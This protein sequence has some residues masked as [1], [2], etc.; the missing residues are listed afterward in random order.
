MTKCKALTGSAVK[1]LKCTTIFSG[2]WAP[3]EPAGRV[4]SVS[5]DSIRG[6]GKGG[7][8]QEWSAAGTEIGEEIERGWRWKRREMEDKRKGSPSKLILWMHPCVSVEYCCSVSPMELATFHIHS[9][10]YDT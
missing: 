5:P 6:E 10:P 4:H 1:G 2:G 8:R 3:S 9:P 7:P